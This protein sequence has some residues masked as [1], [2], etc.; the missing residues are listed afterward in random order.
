MQTAE[1]RNL[2]SSIFCDRLG[3]LQEMHDCVGRADVRCILHGQQR[4]QS[5]Q[6]VGDVRQS[7]D[8]RLENVQADAII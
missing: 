2:I 4:H 6:G 1:F 8:S 5:V 7:A 3:I